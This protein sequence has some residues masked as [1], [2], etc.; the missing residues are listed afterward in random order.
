MTRP[1]VIRSAGAA[2]GLWNAVGAALQ[3]RHGVDV[4]VEFAPVGA[5][6]DRVRNRLDVNA[7]CDLIILTPAL[8]EQLRDAFPGR[9]APAGTLGTTATTLASREGAGD[10][11]IS[12]EAALR[13]TLASLDRV[14]TGDTQ[15]STVG[16]HLVHVM[17]ELGLAGTDAP[18]IQA[19]AGGQAAVAALTAMHERVLACA[20]LTEVREVIGA[21]PI[22]PFP[23]RFH[24][25]TEY[26]L[27]VVDGNETARAVAAD[28]TATHTAATRR[29][30][31]FED[32]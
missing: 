28:L 25:A 10:F 9:I 13:Q 4:D 22:G 15:K 7:P 14:M 24:L 20:Q 29:R 21:V 11:D 5:V 26:A 23:G 8:I 3:D 32:C 1:L 17:A 27:A 16:R 2:K 19:Y 12:S 18:T 6:F 31:G 30:C